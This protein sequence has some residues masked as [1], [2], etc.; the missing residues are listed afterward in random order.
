MK[1]IFLLM[2]FV[3]LFT[4]AFSIV[5]QRFGYEKIEVN[6]GT[7]YGKITGSTKD[8]V[9]IIIAGSGP[10]DMDGNSPLV[11][12]RADY[13]LEMAEKLPG[14]HVSVFCYDKRTAGKSAESFN[15]IEPDFNLL[16][17]DAVAVI[18]YVKKMGYE[19]IVILGHSEGALV[20]MLAALLEP[21]DGYISLGGPGYPIDI[22]LEKQLRTQLPDDAL[23][24]QV[25]RSLR[26]GM[27][28]PTVSDDH[29]LF[30]LPNQEYVLSWMEHDPSQIIRRLQIP[31][32]IIHG[33]ADLQVGA[34]NFYA[35]QNA[36][37][38]G[39]T[40]VISDMNHVLKQV[41]TEDENAASY[42]DPSFPVHGELLEGVIGFVNSFR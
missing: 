41:K 39:K 5:D 32:L 2:S 9:V 28:V 24:F 20:G 15:H 38:T 42:T 26:E 23:E 31:V 29:P 11:Q 1:S 14:R 13:F 6:G 17:S 22:I 19:K 3:V 34:D 37:P 30:S 18:R 35:L 25:I 40:L 33:M 7:L 12:G 16:V 4:A 10:T 27:T 8:P 21:V 36:A